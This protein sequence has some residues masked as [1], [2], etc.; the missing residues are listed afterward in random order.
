MSTKEKNNRDSKSNA[1]S[2]V[3][4]PGEALRER[5]A[6]KAYELYLKRGRSDGHELEDW[7]EAERQ[8]ASDVQ[9]ELG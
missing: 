5:I 9:T 6:A 4:I 1:A 7:L 2:S 3:S 8:V